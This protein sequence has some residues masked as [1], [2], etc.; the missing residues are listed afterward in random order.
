ML[1]QCPGWDLSKGGSILMAS[2]GPWFLRAVMLPPF[3]IG[4]HAL[5]FN[6]IRRYL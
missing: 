3:I 6:V 1:S 2:P 5:R 4:R